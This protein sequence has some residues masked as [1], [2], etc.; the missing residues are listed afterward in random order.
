MRH[1]PY[2][3][4]V[5]DLKYVPMNPTELHHKGQKSLAHVIEWDK[6]LEFIYLY[7]F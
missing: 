3:Q 4:I 1:D 2:V 6:T 5:M 7:K